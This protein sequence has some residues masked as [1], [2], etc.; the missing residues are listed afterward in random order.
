ML[1]RFSEV[2]NK[3]ISGTQHSKLHKKMSEINLIKKIIKKNYPV[4]RES[5]LIFNK[6]TYNSKNKN[7]QNIILEEKE[8]PKSK[9][10]NYFNIFTL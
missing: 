2:S 8:I 10:S 4:S 5:I 1:G 9:L 7:N 3:I 6:F